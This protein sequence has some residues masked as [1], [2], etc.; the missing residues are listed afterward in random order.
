MKHLKS[1]QQLNEEASIFKR[2]RQSVAGYKKSDMY[3]SEKFPSPTVAEITPDKLFG[4]KSVPDLDDEVLKGYFIKSI[5]DKG[6][7]IRE[8]TRWGYDYRFRDSIYGGSQVWYDQSYHFDKLKKMS[9]SLGYKIGKQVDI[10][11]GGYGQI[12]EIVKFAFYKTDGDSCEEKLTLLYK[13]DEVYYQITQIELSKENRD[14]IIDDVIKEN[15]Y[16]LLD[17]G[18]ISYSS[19]PISNVFKCQ[20]IVNDLTTLSIL[21]RISESLSVAQS[22][23]KDSNID[24][25]IDNISKDSNGKKQYVISFTCKPILKSKL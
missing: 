12:S 24:L 18:V 23:L 13:V 10:I 4:G 1:Y 5:S 6:V 15:F 20:I 22:R 21:S 25:E 9:D 16:D 11:G 3:I 8:T 2:I 14:N 19:T 7:F 17:D